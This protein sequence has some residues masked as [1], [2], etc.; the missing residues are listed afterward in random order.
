MDTHN[1]HIR[2]TDRV[3]TRL[4]L[5]QL[6]LLVV[7]AERASIL[8]AA[9]AL[10]ISQP[11]AT[12]LIKD[13]E[14]DFGV[15]LFDRTNRGAVPTPFGEAL[16]RHGKLVL[17]QIAQAAQELD[18]LNEGR[19]G[20]IVV[21]TLLA[22]SAK[23]LPRTICRVRAKRPNVS[24]TVR[25]GTNHLLMPALAAGDLDMV[26]GRLP[27]F[28][29]RAELVQ[30]RLFDE[31]V[32]IVA[33]AG[34]PLAGRGSVALSDLAACDWILPLQETTLRRQIEK[35]F[36]D[37]G[38]APRIAVESVSFQT[39]RALLQSTDL[40]GIVPAH[41]VEQEARLGVLSVIPCDLGVS[42]GPVGVSFRQ[43]G[44]LSP[45]AA[46]FLQELREVARGLR[47]PA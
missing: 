2:I 43:V 10:N 27:E 3:L 26:V 32:C 29:H 5:K 9:E 17:A 34:H 22:A 6:R 18:D 28:R 35:A 41:V 33:R 7:V 4:K 40:I 37:H 24:V 16:V 47:H 12:K 21:G 19:G 44:G 11:A 38:M 8:H 46:A 45:A 42:I 15:R 31:A 23:L 39:N 1:R 13:L 36:H 14:A 25:D 20:R 30:E